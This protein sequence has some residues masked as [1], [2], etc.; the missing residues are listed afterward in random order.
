MEYETKKCQFQYCSKIDSNFYDIFKLDYT[1]TKKNIFTGSW[2]IPKKIAICYN[3]LEMYILSDDN[4]KNLFVH[5]L[6]SSHLT[7]LQSNWRFIN[8]WIFRI[9]HHGKLILIEIG[10]KRVTILLLS[11]FGR[12]FWHFVLLGPLMDTKFFFC[13]HFPAQATFW[14]SKFLLKNWLTEV[15]RSRQSQPFRSTNTSATTRKSR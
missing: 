15:T 12:F 3:Y 10:E 7:Q 8:L 2:I 6:S 9:V 5:S 11:N 4:K 14:C 13:F 1:I